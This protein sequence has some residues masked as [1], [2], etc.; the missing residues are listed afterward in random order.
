MCCVCS[1]KPTILLNYSSLEI[2]LEKGVSSLGRYEG[3]ISSESLRRPEHGPAWSDLQS[4]SVPAPRNSESKD[5]G[6]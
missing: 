1:E 2:K 6:H 4:C 5:F 3:L